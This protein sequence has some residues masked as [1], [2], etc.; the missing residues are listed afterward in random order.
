MAIRA[1]GI[2]SEGQRT[3]V[4]HVLVSWKLAKGFRCSTTKTNLMSAFPLV[5]LFPLSDFVRSFNI[6][7]LLCDW[8][9]TTFSKETASIMHFCPNTF[10]VV[11]V[12]LVKSTTQYGRMLNVI[13]YATWLQKRTILS[14]YCHNSLLQSWK[15]IKTK[16]SPFKDFLICVLGQ[17]K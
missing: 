12:I 2:F 5:Y 3:P 4:Y 8:I 9:Y 6:H 14:D 13:G 17:K 1:F 10:P 16:N 15:M 7:I 11:K